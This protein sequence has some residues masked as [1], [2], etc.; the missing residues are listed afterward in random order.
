MT[1]R[2]E[3]VIGAAVMTHP[4]RRAVAAALAARLDHWGAVVAEDPL[5]GRPPAT[6][7]AARAAWAAI[8][9]GASH[10]L[11]LQDDVELCADFAR[12]VTEAVS[13][14]PDTPLALYANSSAV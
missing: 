8:A 14:H 13:R 12:L 5:P 10:H 3:P 2:T 9:P 11:V 1:H 7:R 4:A 6:L